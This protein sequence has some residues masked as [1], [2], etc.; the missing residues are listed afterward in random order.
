M[1]IIVGG[2]FDKNLMHDGENFHIANKIISGSIYV[3]VNLF[4]LFL[5]NI[6]CPTEIL[7]SILCSRVY[8]LKKMFL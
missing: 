5:L 1:D 8:I 4:S 2:N 7:T 6:S 3:E